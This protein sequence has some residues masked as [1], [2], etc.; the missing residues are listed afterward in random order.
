MSWHVVRKPLVIGLL[1]LAAAGLALAATPRTRVADS[2]EKID[3]ERMIPESF[4][5]WRIDPSIVP[6]VAF[7][8]VRS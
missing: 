4:G 8:T 2:Q 1:M 3:L 5:E 6:L 7:V